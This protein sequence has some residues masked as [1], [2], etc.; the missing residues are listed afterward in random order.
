M[1]NKM[2]EK[3]NWSLKL[4]ILSFLNIKEIYFLGCTNKLNF[5]IFLREKIQ[6]KSHQNLNNSSSSCLSFSNR[7][8]LGY[9]WKR[10]CV[11]IASYPRCGNSFLRKLLETWSGI[12]TGA[13]SHPCRTLSSS[14]LSCGF[15]VNLSTS[16]PLF[17]SLSSLN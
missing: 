7:R 8:F 3:F 11:G 13:D 17:F 12:I 1:K 15:Q 4:E 5:L 2:C 6:R 14:L 10:D 9:K 16:F